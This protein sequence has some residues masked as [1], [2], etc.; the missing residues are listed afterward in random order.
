[1][2]ITDYNMPDMDGFD[3]TRHLRKKHGKEDLAIIAVSSSDHP[4]VSSR[5]LK[6]GASDFLSKPFTK[7]ELVS[8]V[9]MNIEMLEAIAAQRAT[10]KQIQTLHQALIAEQRQARVKQVGMVTNDFE[11]DSDFLVQTFY[12]ASDI[13]S[14]DAYSLHKTLEGGAFIYL[15]DGMGHGLCPLL[16]PLRLRRR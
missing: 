14:G 2:V 7:E 3:L 1:M 5:F 8:R 4:D 16:R 11:N 15:I 9:H 6:Y 12:K 10:A 13:L